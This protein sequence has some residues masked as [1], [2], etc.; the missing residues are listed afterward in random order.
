MAMTWHPT[1]YPGVRYREHDSRLHAGEKD[2]YYSIRCK[3]RGRDIE[4]GL[5]WAS[6]GITPEHARNE[7]AKLRASLRE[8]SGHATGVRRRKSTVSFSRFWERDYLPFLK[9]SKAPSSVAVETGIYSN[10]LGPSFGDLPLGRL[11]ADRL[12]SLV[13]DVLEANRSPRTARYIVSV[14]S[15]VWNLALEKNYDLP[16]N[17]CPRVS[18]SSAGRTIRLARPA[19]M[20]KMLG[21][22][23]RRNGDL[24]DAVILA[25]FCGLNPGELFR[26][27]WAAVDLARGTIV[28][29][30]SRHR[31]SRMIYLPSPVNELLAKRNWE[32]F[33]RTGGMQL[34]DFVFPRKAGLKREWF[35]RAFE[36]IALEEGWNKKSAQRRERITF[37]TFR[38]MYAI[39]LITGGIGLSTVAELMGH[40]TIS[41]LQK[42]ARFAPSPEALCRSVLDAEW[43][44]LL[45]P[46]SA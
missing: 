44:S 13:A 37:A 8:T 25:L 5:G 31:R 15:R 38:H 45:E 1:P 21:V 20:R 26:L 32:S 29:R 41:L 24:H 17:P 34:T 28:V 2:R 22:L 39:W 46:P 35:S 10:W 36:R 12:E 27:S 19:E 23:S 16:E 14:I 7:L 42:Y 3:I 30:E 4:R 33:S 11:T 6:S 18:V 43:K 9:K 40:K